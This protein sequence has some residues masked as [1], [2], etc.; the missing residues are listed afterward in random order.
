MRNS[1][2]LFV[3]L[4]CACHSWR[5]PVQRLQSSRFASGHRREDTSDNFQK[6]NLL[7]ALSF[8]LPPHR[9]A[10]LLVRSGTP[11]LSAAEEDEPSTVA[12]E[13]PQ[14]VKASTPPQKEKEAM[15]MQSW[16]GFLNKKDDFQERLGPG[17]TRFV[18]GGSGSLVATPTG[19]GA[20]QT[21]KLFPG[22]LIEVETECDV[23]WKV[24]EP[25]FLLTTEFEQI[26]L[27][28][29]VVAA[30]VIFFALLITKA[31]SMGS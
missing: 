8:A 5:V 14:Y 10:P 24:D 12:A 22:I 19:G 6:V 30:V 3:G 31:S 15:G 26:G 17:K 4:A 2:I 21:V 27:Y 18:Q 9:N 13:A 23:A 16:P 25:L 11:R 20:P 29:A 7:S 28:L 1:I